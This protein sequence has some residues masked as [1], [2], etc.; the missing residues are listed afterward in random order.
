[1]SQGAALGVLLSVGCPREALLMAGAQS[2]VETAGWKSMRNFNAG[3][4]TA[5]NPSVQ[6]WMLQGSNAIRFVAYP[7][8]QAGF[9][10]FLAWLSTHGLLAHAV[11]N[12]LPGYIAQLRSNCYLGCIGRVDANGTTVSQTD[13]DNYQ[14]GISAWMTKLRAVA[15]ILPADASANV[16]RSGKGTAI[17]LAI[18]ALGGAVAYAIHEGI[19]IPTR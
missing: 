19:L 2:A 12:D 1:M 18:L 9:G 10:A 15:P 11:A 13:Y 3:N 7:T 5:T 14:A 17:A 8:P 16:A 4:I 6:P